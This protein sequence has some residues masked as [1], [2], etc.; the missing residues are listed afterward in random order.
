MAHP[1][2]TD[3]FWGFARELLRYRGLTTAALV[4]V[5]LSG[6]TLSAGLLGAVPVMEAILG[7]KQHLGDLAARFNDT[8][9]KHAPWAGALRI[10]D[11]VIA[12]LPTDPFTSLAWIMGGLAVLTVFGAACNYLHAYYSLT[13]VNRAVTDIRRRAF[14]TVIRSPLLAILKTGTSDPISRIVNDTGQLANGLAVLTSKAVL[15]VVKGAGAMVI[16]FAMDWRVTT[17]ALTVAP[18]LYT[19]IRKLGKRI[20]RAANAALQS[21]AGLFGAANESLQALRVVKVH[22][23][24]RLEGGRFHRMNKE[25]LRELNRVRT[26]RALASPLTEALSIFLLC[27]LVLVAGRAIIAG[28]LDPGKFIL[29]L[30]SLAVAGASL[31]PLT[32]I[33]NDLQATHPAAVRLQELLNRPP[34]PGHGM[35]LARLARHAESVAFDGVSLTYPGATREALRGVTLRVPHGKRYAFVGPNGCGKTSLLGLVPRLYDPTQGRMLIDGR[36]VREVSVRSLREQIGVVTQE[37]VLFRGSVRYNISYG[38]SATQEQ[39]VEAAKRARAHEFITRL[40]QGYDTV[41]SEG[42]AGLSG[43]QRQRLAIARAIL[44]NPAILILDEATSMVDAESEA[45]ITEAL[46]DFA[47]GRTALIVAHR[48]STVLSCDAIVVMRDGQ[49]EDVGT[50]KELLQRCETYQNLARHHFGTDGK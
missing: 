16:A 8:L 14:H 46:T 36:D 19:I 18:L 7:S 41:L 22:T 50:H 23:T 31:K 47:V 26:A 5:V 32:G 43:G 34:E 44:R 12:A 13:V 39:I 21:Q 45:Q 35:K 20:K 10:P 4:F 15:Q 33:V 38:S 37:T 40:P 28:H 24:E 49:I 3:P 2:Q 42:G 27:G 9:A 17:A 48:L 1:K 30:S 11:T 25:M 29:A 6:V